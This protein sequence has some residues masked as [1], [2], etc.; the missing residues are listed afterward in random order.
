M[1]VGT[2]FKFYMLCGSDKAC[3][4]LI[5]YIFPKRE[6]FAKKLPKLALIHQTASD[7]SYLH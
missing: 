1:D 7:Q 5:A 2:P 3:P 6:A 4:V